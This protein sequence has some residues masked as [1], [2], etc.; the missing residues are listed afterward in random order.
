[1]ANRHWVRARLRLRAGLP[2]FLAAGKGAHDAECGGVDV[3][4][5]VL[6]VRCE[7]EA[8]AHDERPVHAGFVE[9]PELVDEK[10][11]LGS[12][13]SWVDRPDPRPDEP[14]DHR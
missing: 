12:F 13:V 1:M 5:R 2:G 10:S 3:V 7:R 9:Q 6:A 11:G 14:P 8:E 4:A